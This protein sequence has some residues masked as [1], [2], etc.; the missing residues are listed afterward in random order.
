M[1]TFYFMFDTP[2]GL[3]QMN[4]AAWS[5]GR[6]VNLW[7]EHWRFSYRLTCPRVRHWTPCCSWW[8]QVV[9]SVWIH[10]CMI[11]CVCVWVNSDC[12][13][14][15]AFKISSKSINKYTPFIILNSW[16]EQFAISAFRYS[17]I[18]DFLENFR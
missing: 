2:Q 16:K 6:V 8:L 3:K 4:V 9:A 7:L 17:N 12:K 15:W 11:I 10:H 1:I 13:A 18:I 14:P 5:R